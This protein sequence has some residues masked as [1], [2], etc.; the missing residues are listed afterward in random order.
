MAATR[1]KEAT[2]RLARSAPQGRGAETMTE[3]AVLE[4]IAACLRNQAR[5]QQSVNPAYARE[6]RA[7]AAMHAQRAL[8]LPG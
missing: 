8:R 1:R 3:R 6:L 4:L 5:E 7:R 2:Y